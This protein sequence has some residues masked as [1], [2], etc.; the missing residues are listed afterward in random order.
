MQ[1]RGKE[2]ANFAS[3]VQGHA[4]PRRTHSHPICWF[5]S[6]HIIHCEYRPFGSN[7]IG[8]F[9]RANQ[10]LRIHPTRHSLCPLGIFL[11]PCRKIT[12]LLQRAR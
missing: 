8:G 12:Y 2:G 1:Q 6:Y 7:L 9:Y 10:H 3:R 5:T 4:Q 11:S